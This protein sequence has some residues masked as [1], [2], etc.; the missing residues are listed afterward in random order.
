[1]PIL[2]EAITRNNR[3]GPRSKF[4]II[5]FFILNAAFLPPPLLWINFLSIFYFFKVLN[6]KSF[7]TLIGFILLLS[8]FSVIHFYNG[9]HTESYINSS[10]IYILVAYTTLAVRQ[11]LLNNPIKFDQF[12][13]EMVK[14]N[15]ILFTVGLI[16]FYFEIPSKIFVVYSYG[17]D[18]LPR[19]RGLMYEPSYYAFFLTPWI[20]YALFKNI[21]RKG[22]KSE[23]TYF[24]FLI[25]PFVSTA[26]IGVLSALL[27]SLIIVGAL[28]SIS[29]LKLNRKI[30]FFT[31]T[32][33]FILT[34]LI[35]SYPQAILSRAGSILSGEDGSANQRTIQSLDVS[36]Q[37]MK[38]KSTLF[39]IGSGQIKI[40]GKDIFNNYFNY[41]EYNVP[42]I[43]NAVGETMTTFGFVGLAIR[44]IIELFI[45]V[46]FKVYNNNYLLT[47][48]LFL[49]IYQFTGSFITST[50]EYVFWALITTPVFREFNSGFKKI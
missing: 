32:F 17:G 15:F 22:S 40:T 9:V 47:V 3:L 49:F 6:S 10:L 45:F 34:I 42:R 30:V 4:L 2:E 11:Y 20:A 50:I 41:Q 28:R 24:I 39:G 5:V 21:Q 7:F 14:Y 8:M 12:Y 35:L 31:T 29:Y 38:E 33:V 16:L 19:M 43:P 27:L 13:R 46:R 36:Y 37:I 48:F 25:I 44:L 1:M 23:L 26:S 18:E